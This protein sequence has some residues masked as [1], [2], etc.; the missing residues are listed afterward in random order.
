MQRPFEEL[1]ATSLDDLYAGALYL[2]AGD[3]DAAAD[4]LVRTLLLARG[5]FAETNP[6]SPRDWLDERLVRTFLSRTSWRPSSSDAHRPTHLHALAEA[7][8]AATHVEAD[9]ILDGFG[10]LPPRVRSTMWL[11]VVRRWAYGDVARALEV[12]RS[13]I[14]EWVRQGHRR[15][16]QTIS[17]HQVRQRKRGASEL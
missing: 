1:V 10:A 16:H 9:Q 3:R 12:D 2:E 15:M 7:A 5:P 14:G 11:V 17:G 6:G 13:R 4:L 8:A